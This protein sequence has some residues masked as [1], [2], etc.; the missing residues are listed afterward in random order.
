MSISKSLAEGTRFAVIKPIYLILA[1]ILGITASLVLSLVFRYEAMTALQYHLPLALPYLACGLIVRLLLYSRFG[2]FKEVWRHASFATVGRI[3]Q[4]DTWSSV[5][6]IIIDFFIL[7]NLGISTIESSAVLLLDWV[8]NLF[9]LG[10]SR[11]L[12][13]IVLSWLIA[14]RK[15][16]ILGT[17]LPKRNVLIVGAGDV[18]TTVVRMIK[19]NPELGMVAVG[20]ADDDPDKL[21]STILDVKVFGNRNDIP[22]LVK[23]LGV[24]EVVIAMPTVPEETINEVRKICAQVPVMVRAIPSLYDLLTGTLTVD[25]IRQWRSLDGYHKFAARHVIEPHAFQNIMVTGGAGFIGS[26]FVRY[27]LDSYPS[28]RIIVYDKLT[29]AGNLDNLLGLDEQYKDRYVFVQGDISDFKFVSSTVRDYEV[30]AIVNFAAETHVDRSLM[31]PWSFLGANVYGTYT[32]LEVARQYDVSRFHQVSTDEVYGQVIHGSFHEEDPLETRSPY[33]ASKAAG[34][35][36]AYAYY[37]SFGVPVTITR[38]SNSIGPN[39]YPE[40]AVPLFVTNAIDNEPLPIYGDGLYVRDYQYVLDHCRG[41]DV[42]LHKGE[43]GQIYNLGGGNEK[44]TLELARSIL[45]RL[46]RPYS[47]IRLVADRPGQDRRYSLNCSK[48]KALG[49]EAQWSYETS[50][51]ATVQWY[52]E[53]E[54]WWRKI[55]SGEY[56]QYYQKQFRERLENAV[57]IALKDYQE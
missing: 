45:Y 42:V 56:R 2:M 30:D 48:I 26:N 55:K 35:L 36:L 6:L 52:L 34:D 43:I 21:S 47:L 10:G 13:R 53:N 33:S 40:K 11:F 46:G 8:I 28:Y 37:N 22:E 3:L 5:I 51:D 44:T 18:G 29:Y 50:M 38:G 24:E 31:E 49:W 23:K 54:W 41:I 57:H 1:D 39:Q 7:K 16:E 27:I 17:L 12:L 32:L 9:Y 20:F 25:Q 15:K 19:D 14:H 4:A